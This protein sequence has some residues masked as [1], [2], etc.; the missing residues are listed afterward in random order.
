MRT[1]VKHFRMLVAALAMGAVVAACSD[2]DSYSIKEA[3][4]DGNTT[5][6]GQLEAYSHVTSFNLVTDADAE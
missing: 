3:R 5:V 1:T 6:L 4:L 2:D